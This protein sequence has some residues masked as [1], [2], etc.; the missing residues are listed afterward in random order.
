MLT[1][2]ERAL[3]EYLTQ[4]VS[5]ERNALFHRILEHRTRHITVVLENIYQP[6]N[7]SAVLRSCDCFGVQDIHA[8]ENDN[9]LDVSKGVTIGVDKWLTVEKY[10]SEQE[11]TIPCL[12]KLKKQGYQ[13]VATSPHADGYELSELPVDKPIAVMLGQEKPG[14]TDEALDM[15]D[16]HLRIPMYGFSESYNISVSAALCLYDL[17]ERMRAA[18]GLNWQLLE[19]EKEVLELNWIR[20]SVQRVSVIEREF[21]KSRL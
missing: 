18:N 21:L 2:D 19:E 4:F 3:K 15:A 12:T 13:L 17:T 20:K 9:H 11:N 6:H 1:A 5:E 7:A 8:I 10:R 16:M 14:L